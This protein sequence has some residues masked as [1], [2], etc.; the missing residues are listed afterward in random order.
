MA[1]EAL[2]TATAGRS[3]ASWWTAF[4]SPSSNAGLVPS[5]VVPTRSTRRGSWDVQHG[6]RN[7]PKTM[8][9]L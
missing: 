3:I 8:E 9:K 5:V 7:L 2:P 1:C 6:Y 4:I